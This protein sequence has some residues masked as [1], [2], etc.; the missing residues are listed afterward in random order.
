MA[1]Y[2]LDNLIPDI[3]ESAY[4]ADEASVIGDR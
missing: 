3:H 4:I 2:R 1:I